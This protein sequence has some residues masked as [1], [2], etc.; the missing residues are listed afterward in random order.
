ML[1]KILI[2]S[3]TCKD[4]KTYDIGRILWAFSIVS[5][6]CMGAYSIWEGQTWSAAEYGAG[7]SALL[8][9]GGFGIAIKSKAEPL[10]EN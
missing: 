8:A 1:R 9:G 4:N 6:V 5:Y 2:Q 3:F 7:L 10:G